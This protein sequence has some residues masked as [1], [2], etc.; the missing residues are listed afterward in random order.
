VDDARGMRDG[1]SIYRAS[2]LSRLLDRSHL[3]DDERAPR[4]AF[5]FNLPMTHIFRRTTPP[6]ASKESLK[7]HSI[8]SL[9]RGCV[10]QGGTHL[11][12]NY[13]VFCF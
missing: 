8:L 2:I 10:G 11:N 6:I 7:E 13:R 4:A 9:G 1:V 12:L 5:F 3:H